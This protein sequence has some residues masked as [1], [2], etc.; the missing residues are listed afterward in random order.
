[1]FS[2]AGTFGRPGIVIISPV[3]ATIKPAPAE[4]LTFL[5]FTVKFSG[6]PNNAGLSEKL[7]CVF[8]TQIGSLLKPKLSSLEISSSALSV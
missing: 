7:Y 4:T 8:A 5:T 1:M 6:A 2:A 3:S